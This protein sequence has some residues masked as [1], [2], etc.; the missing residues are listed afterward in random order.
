[1]YRSIDPLM[2][3]P[4]PSEVM[5][6]R[7]KFVQNCK[8][9]TSKINKTI[10]KSLGIDPANAPQYLDGIYMPNSHFQSITPLHA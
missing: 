7:S 4:S 8:V 1:M 9:D 5:N 6:Y 3:I 10:L 2:R